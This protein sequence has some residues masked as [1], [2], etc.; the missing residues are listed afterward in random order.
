MPSIHCNKSGGPTMQFPARRMANIM[1]L[2][3]YDRQM[4]ADVQDASDRTLMLDAQRQDY[5]RSQAD[6][7]LQLD[8]DQIFGFATK[9]QNFAAS[10]ADEYKV[11]HFQA[12]VAALRRVD[13]ATNV[14]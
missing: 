12:D 8:H 6:R 13:L 7:D 14:C 4:L 11:L 9:L 2:R 5:G 3:C 1:C 10:D